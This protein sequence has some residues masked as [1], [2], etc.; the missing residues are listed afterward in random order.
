MLCASN[1]QKLFA[2]FINSWAYLLDLAV[3]KYQITSLFLSFLLSRKGHPQLSV[4]GSA[5]NQ[6]FHKV[7][8]ILNCSEGVECKSFWLKRLLGYRCKRQGEKYD[9]RT[10]QSAESFG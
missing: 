7:G 10:R 5:Y 1:V 8:I 9:W 6:A 3:G 2:T 4:S